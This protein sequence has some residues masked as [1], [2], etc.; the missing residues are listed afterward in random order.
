MTTPF[1]PLFRIR[2]SLVKEGDRA[3]NMFL[4]EKF[5]ALA[6]R[7]EGPTHKE[8]I[9]MALGNRNFQGLELPRLKKGKLTVP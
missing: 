3:D 9:F 2:F 1:P 5:Q 7:I 4:Q 6:A 8:G